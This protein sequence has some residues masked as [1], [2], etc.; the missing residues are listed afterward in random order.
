MIWE[1]AGE[2]LTPRQL[3][4]VTSLA[5]CVPPDVA[6]MIAPIEVEALQRRA[7]WLA[8]HG[9]LPGDDSGG[10]YPWPLV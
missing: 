5:E 10:R 8:E 6:E 4:A 3:A 1:F 7:G 2:E 9:V